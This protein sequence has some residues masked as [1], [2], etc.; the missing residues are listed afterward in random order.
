M[1]VYDFDIL[2]RC[3]GGPTFLRPPGERDRQV[4]TVKAVK[5]FVKPDGTRVPELD[6][7]LLAQP[8]REL[9][10]RRREYGKWV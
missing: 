3:V 4:F 10:V 2:P 1:M 8:H 5:P 7:V 6:V 9:R